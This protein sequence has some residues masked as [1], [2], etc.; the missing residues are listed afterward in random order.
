MLRIVSLLCLAASLLALDVGSPAPTFSLTAADGS[1]V[2]LADHTGGYV[3]LEWINFD[4]P[5]VA[6]HYGSGNLPALQ[7]RY[8]DQGVTWLSIC[9]SAPGKQ[10]H[11]S[12]DAL[13]QRIQ[14]EGWA[15]DAYLLDPE[16][17]VGQGY[18]AKT[19]PQIFIIDPQGVLIYQGGIDSIRSADQ[20]DIA[21]ATPYVSESLDAAMAGQPVPNPSTKPYGCSVKY[22]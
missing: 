16:G 9:S 2:A 17:T 13:T 4:C 18:G 11:F 15:G 20:A 5:F 8:R 3:V 1:Q 7:Q 19:T 12:G 22:P 10:G 14:Q 6:K 21:K